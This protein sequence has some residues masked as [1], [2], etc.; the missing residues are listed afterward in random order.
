MLRSASLDD[1]LHITMKGQGR[2]FKCLWLNDGRSPALMP[3][4]S[5]GDTSGEQHPVK[6]VQRTS[7]R[8]KVLL[9]VSGKIH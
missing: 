8:T 1:S 5:R 3:C 2:I 7:G 6:P 9:V 4:N